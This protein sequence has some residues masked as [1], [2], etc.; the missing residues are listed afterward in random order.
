[1]KSAKEYILV[2][3]LTSKVLKSSENYQEIKNL[4]T[5]IRKGG[6]QVTIFKST[7]G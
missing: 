1:M 5:L 6:G 7:K 3:D 2:S 4:A